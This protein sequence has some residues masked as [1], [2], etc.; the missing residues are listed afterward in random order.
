MGVG[1][2][3]AELPAQKARLLVASHCR[4][5]DLLEDREGKLKVLVCVRCRDT[6]AEAGQQAGKPTITCARPRS[7][8][9]RETAAALA[10]L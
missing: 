4:V 6:H 5:H 3:S 9:M 7:S 2:H 8:P 10:G 1:G